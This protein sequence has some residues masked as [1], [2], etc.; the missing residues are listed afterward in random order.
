[1][2]DPYTCV[3]HPPSVFLP[4]GSSLL[5]AYRLTAA[6]GLEVR[7][8]YQRGRAPGQ[9]LLPEVRRRGDPH[10]DEAGHT[11]QRGKEGDQED[12]ADLPV[13]AGHGPVSEAVARDPV[14][15][16]AVDASGVHDQAA[17]PRQ[18]EIG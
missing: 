2:W 6:A 7:V 17:Q 18:D 9:G 14:A 4:P 15:L 16:Q 5:P 11:G 3:A 10:V 12:P 13:Q 1:M 8:G